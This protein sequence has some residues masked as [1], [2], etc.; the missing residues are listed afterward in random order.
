M[1]GTSCARHLKC[2]SNK[3]SISHYIIQYTKLV[4][5]LKTFQT[6]CWY[7]SSSIWYILSRLYW[8]ICRE[9]MNGTRSTFLI[10]MSTSQ[11]TLYKHCEYFTNFTN[12]LPSCFGALQDLTSS[13]FLFVAGSITQTYFIYYHTVEI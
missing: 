7:V 6:V 3:K 5:I 1:K 12:Q 4:N 11:Y 10:K 8:C 13:L 2:L 9:Y